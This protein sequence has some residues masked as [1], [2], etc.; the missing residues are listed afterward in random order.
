MKRASVQ[1]QVSRVGWFGT[2]I[3]IPGSPK[4]DDKRT[5]LCTGGML[6]RMA[7]NK[8]RDNPLADIGN[9]RLTTAGRGSAVELQDRNVYFNFEMAK[10]GECGTQGTSTNARAGGILT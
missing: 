3:K 6:I 5:G 7:K 4:F 9:T 8:Q 10:E 2:F 1:P